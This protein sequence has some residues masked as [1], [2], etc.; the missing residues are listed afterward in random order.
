MRDGQEDY[1]YY[2]LLEKLAKQH[3]DAE[4]LKLIDEIRS[5]AIYP[6]AGGRKSAEFLPNPEVIQILRNKV[7][8]HIERLS[9]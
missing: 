9:N 2:I 3:N 5:L 1:E 6:N 4:A 8:E 7:A